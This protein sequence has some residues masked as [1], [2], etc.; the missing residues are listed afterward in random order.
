MRLDE[1]DTLDLLPL[2]PLTVTLPA[3]STHGLGRRVAVRLA[4]AITEMGTLEIHAHAV[5][6]SGHWQVALNVRQP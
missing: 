1:D 4:V 6:G 3:T 5:D 2:P